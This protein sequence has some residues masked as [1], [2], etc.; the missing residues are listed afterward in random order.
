[1]LLSEGVD[2]TVAIG[3]LLGMI[4]RL[5]QVKGSWTGPGDWQQVRHS[6]LEVLEVMEQSLQ[7]L[8]EDDD[9]VGARLY[10]EHYKM[11]REMDRHTPARLP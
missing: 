10:G 3:N 11:I 2:P 4:R 8:F 7:S 6:Y 5:E 1:M 9:G